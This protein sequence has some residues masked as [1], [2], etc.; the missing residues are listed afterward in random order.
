V[1]SIE[2]TIRRATSS[3]A[4]ERL[5]SAAHHFRLAL[6]YN[7]NWH[8][9]P[10]A[11]AGHPNGG[12]WI[13]FLTPIASSL[14]PVLQRLG[15]GVIARLRQATNQL[16]PALRR[17]PSRWDD[18][19]A[20]PPDENFDAETRRISRDSWQRHGYPTIRFRS[21]D[22]LRRYL[23]PAGL[24]REWH[25]IVERR[26]AE[27]GMFL[28]EQIHSTDNIISLPIE[29]HRSISARMSS[30]SEKYQGMVRRF[31]VER[32]RFAEQ[33]NE[34][35]DLIVETLMEFGYDPSKF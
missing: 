25:H 11:P 2:Q 33:Y 29:V 20:L 18:I 35:L 30:R 3:I 22:E 6:K 8:L 10:R 13:S 24:G 14:L 15:P 23:G 12:Q 9:Q 21:E 16:A 7:P 26:L 5:F 1:R 4:A 32:L 19:S 27:M 28:P 31:G 17:L 34:G